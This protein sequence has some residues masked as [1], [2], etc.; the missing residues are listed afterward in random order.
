M[1]RYFRPGLERVLAAH[2]GRAQHVQ[3]DRQQLEADEQRRRV[4]RRDEHAMPA[5]DVSSSAKYSPCAGLAGAAAR[6]DSSTA[7]IAAADRTAASATSARSSIAQRAGDDDRVSVPLPDRSARR[8]RRARASV[9]DRHDASRDEARAQQADQQHEQRAAEQREQRRQRRPVDV[10]ALQLSRRA[11]IIGVAGL[12]VA[13][14][15][16][17]DAAASTSRVAARAA[18]TAP[19]TRITAPAARARRASAQRELAR[20]RP[21]AR[22]GCAS[23]G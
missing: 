20:R 19:G 23:R 18:D 3:R 8:P 14:G 13:A 1:I 16:A 7:A 21:S 17:D 22:R 11:A 12:L 10:R 2:L 5:I 4:L 15:C 9:S 6:H